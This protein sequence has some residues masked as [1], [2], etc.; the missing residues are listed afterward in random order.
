MVNLLLCIACDFG[1]N[2]VIYVAEYRIF[3]S[4]SVAGLEICE[5]TVMHFLPN[6][7]IGSSP[8]VHHPSELIFFAIWDT[9]PT[10]P[11]LA[12]GY[13]AIISR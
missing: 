5:S 11:M 8:Q 10:F 4:L 12:D 7:Q 1:D 9:D 6:A 13:S 3:G 2:L